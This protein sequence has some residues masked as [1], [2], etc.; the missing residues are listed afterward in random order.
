M[1]VGGTTD[2]HLLGGG[3][4][5]MSSTD[6]AASSVAGQKKK[7]NGIEEFGE[8]LRNPTGR[9]VDIAKKVISLMEALLEQGM[10]FSQVSAK[11]MELFKGKVK[12]LRARE[13]Q[14]RGRSCEQYIL[15]AEQIDQVI[16]G[17][18]KVSSIKELCQQILTKQLKELMQKPFSSWLS[19]ANTF[20][21]LLEDG[22]DP[23]QVTQED[24]KVFAQKMEMER[25]QEERYQGFGCPHYTYVADAVIRALEGKQAKV[26]RE[27]YSW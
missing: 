27:D 1:A 14:W 8:F 16:Q 26:T 12:E 20:N 11:D 17:R 13:E 5:G 21:Q 22:A 24:K 9:W 18:Q 15:I 10:D 6:A 19:V 25:F 3:G 4:G 2:G 23:K 7:V